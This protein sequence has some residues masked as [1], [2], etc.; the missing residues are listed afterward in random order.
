[1]NKEDYY[2]NITYPTLKKA[3]ANAE[4]VFRK[5]LGH[6]Q[7]YNFIVSCYSPQS[8]IAGVTDYTNHKKDSIEDIKKVTYKD[9]KLRLMQ[10]LHYYSRTG[11]MFDEVIID[12]FRGGW[13]VTASWKDGSKAYCAP[14]TK[15]EKRRNESLL[16]S[17]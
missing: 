7:E 15:E 3:L 17:I 11:K 9:I 14:L 13:A 1:M 6:W 8:A 4:W 10:N 5:K 2:N 12:L 16:N